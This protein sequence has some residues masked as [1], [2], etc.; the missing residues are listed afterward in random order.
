MGCS[1]SRGGTCS[2][3]SAV[4]S[5]DHKD[6]TCKAMD[7][8]RIGPVFPTILNLGPVWRRACSSHFGCEESSVNV[9]KGVWVRSCTERTGRCFPGACTRLPLQVQAENSCPD[10]AAHIQKHAQRRKRPR[11]ARQGKI[12]GREQKPRQTQQPTNCNISGECGY[13]GNFVMDGSS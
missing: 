8:V 4:V 6:G 9:N 13:R 7:S 10:S 12:H 3:V 1:D 5:D 2:L 11:Q